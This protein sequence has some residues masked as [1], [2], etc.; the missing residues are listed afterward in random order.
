MS[1]TE[2]LAQVAARVAAK[3][4]EP[5]DLYSIDSE[6]MEVIKD[7]ARYREFSGVIRR[8]YD[9]DDI[10]CYSRLRDTDV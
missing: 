6:I 9:F 7:P 1:F 2:Y 8:N 4:K 10:D 3:N 5:T